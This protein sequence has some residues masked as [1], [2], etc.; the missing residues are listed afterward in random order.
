[1][2]S[3][4]RALGAAV[5][6]ECRRRAGH[7]VAAFEWCRR[8]FSDDGASLGGGDD[9]PPI[10]TKDLRNPNLSG[11]QFAF[12]RDFIKRTEGR[13]ERAIGS[14]LVIARED[15]NLTMHGKGAALLERARAVLVQHINL[16]LRDGGDGDGLD[17]S[18]IPPELSGVFTVDELRIVANRTA[19]TFLKGALDS[20][21]G[22][23]EEGEAAASSGGAPISKADFEARRASGTFALPTGA[24][25][26]GGTFEDMEHLTN[27][28]RHHF[29]DAEDDD[30]SPDGADMAAFGRQFERDFREA[31]E[32]HNRKAKVKAADDDDL[33]DSAMSMYRSQG[34]EADA[35]N[36]LRMLRP[37]TADFFRE[38]EMLD[39]KRPD[40]DAHVEPAYAR[41]G[42]LL[43]A[44]CAYAVGRRKRSQAR[45]WVHLSQPGLAEAGTITVNRRP[46]AEIFS[47]SARRSSVAAPL[48]LTGFDAR[49]AVR[50]TVKGGGLMAQAEAIRM[51]IA[52]CIQLLEPARRPTLARNAMLT[53]DPREVERK[54]VGRK[55][56]RKGFQWVKR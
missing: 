4:G 43:S 19:A 16:R 21:G 34:K 35:Y 39:P 54:K 24:P 55:K 45:V 33:V 26:V 11:E 25:P 51:G 40:D 41:G 53:R 50:C 7:R 44:T 5:A 31:L 30:A 38:L 20:A 37:S 2:S 14:G 10:T 56:A 23:I 47:S 49:A 46:I 8:C 27:R 3:L 42:R 32:E 1:M 15:G 12:V 48:V 18:S 29:P 9:H 28:I 22:S 6:S 36:V 17:A 52:R 13:V